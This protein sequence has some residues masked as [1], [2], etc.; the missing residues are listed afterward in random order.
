MT[1]LYFRLHIV[2]KSSKYD[3]VIKYC[4][5]HFH[6]PENILRA[7]ELLNY[8]LY[9]LVFDKVQFNSMYFYCRRRFD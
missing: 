3:D 7:S 1:L 2:A 5:F 9:Y 6:T 8:Y 4:N